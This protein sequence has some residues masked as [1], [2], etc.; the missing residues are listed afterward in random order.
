MTSGSTISGMPTGSQA[1]RKAEMFRTHWW[2]SSGWSGSWSRLH[3]DAGGVEPQRLLD[4]V[5]DELAEQVARQLGAVDVRDVG[6]QHERRLLRPADALEVAAP[7]PGESWIASGAASTSVAI[8]LAWSSIPARNAS[9][10]KKP[11]STATSKQ[12]PSA[13]KRRFS[14]AF[15]R[16]P[17]GPRRPASRRDRA[18]PSVAPTAVVARAP[19][20]LASRARVDEWPAG[21][22]PVDEPRG[23]S[24]A[25]AGAVDSVRRETRARRPRSRR[26]RRSSRRRRASAPPPRRRGRGTRLPRSQAPAL[27]EIPCASARLA[28]RRSRCGRHGWTRSQ[29]PVAS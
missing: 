10:P 5:G 25:G 29:R 11:W 18:R 13:A 12:R 23:E 7:A 9:S 1:A 16:P 15:M 26:L 8:A 3:D 21:E 27:A 2:W 4:G 28:M 19:A 17:R 14:R 24:V 20:A 6:A 22:P